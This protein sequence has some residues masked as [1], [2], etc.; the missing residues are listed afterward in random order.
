MSYPVWH[1]MT[2]S[3]EDAGSPVAGTGSETPGFGYRCHGHMLSRDKGDALN[4]TNR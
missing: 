3:S 2:T 1:L 4:Q